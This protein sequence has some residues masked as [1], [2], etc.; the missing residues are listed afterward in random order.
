MSQQL[1]TQNQQKKHKKKPWNM[2]N[3]VNNTDTRATSFTLICCHKSLTL[4][5][6][7]SHPAAVSTFPVQ[8]D[9][10]QHSRYFLELEIKQNLCILWSE[11]STVKPNLYILNL[12]QSLCIVYS[13]I[14][15]N[16]QGSSNFS[17]PLEPF[18]KP[19]K[20]KILL[21]FDHICNYLQ[22]FYK[23]QIEFVS[24]ILST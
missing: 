23:N 10:C 14:Y 12:T 8:A 19:L 11:Y 21:N 6:P 1:P 7:I 16:L 22:N 20:Q 18:A 13:R 4:Y 24:C 15:Q 17:F 3:K 5:I 2:P 9:K